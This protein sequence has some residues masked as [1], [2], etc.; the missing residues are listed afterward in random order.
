MSDVASPPATGVWWDPE[1]T[2]ASVLLQLRLAGGDVDETRLRGLIPAAGAY[3]DNYLDRETVVEGPP[4]PPLLQEALERKTIT[5]YHGIDLDPAEL[6]W[7]TS[8]HKQRT[9]IA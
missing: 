5:L 3:I 9:A 1:A 6:E 4:P 2:Y 8:P 7:L